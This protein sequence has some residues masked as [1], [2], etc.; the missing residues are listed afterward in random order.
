MGVDEGT[1]AAST[2]LELAIECDQEAVEAVSEVLSR[3]AGGG[4]SVEQPFTTEQEGLAT[5]EHG[6]CACDEGSRARGVG[7]RDGHRDV[8][9]VGR[10]GPMDTSRWSA[11]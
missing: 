8:R 3:V 2:W 6:V 1:S 11:S 5:R 10:T 4:V 7:R 9:G